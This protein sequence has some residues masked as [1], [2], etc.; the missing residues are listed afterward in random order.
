MNVVE[1]SHARE[2]WREGEGGPGGWSDRSDLL[3]RLNLDWEGGDGLY[4]GRLLLESKKAEP[5][6]SGECRC[7]G[8]GRGKGGAFM[9]MLQEKGNAVHCWV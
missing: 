5:L 3:I 9:A 4:R 6:V 7:G 2:G 1:A 8:G